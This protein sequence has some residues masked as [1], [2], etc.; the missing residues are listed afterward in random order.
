M[1]LHPRVVRIQSKRSIG[2]VALIGLVPLALF[3]WAQFWDGGPLHSVFAQ[4]TQPVIHAVEPAPPSCLILNSDISTERTLII[5]GVDLRSITNPRLQIRRRLDRRDPYFIFGPEVNWESNRR[6]TLD[7][8]SLA[9][10]LRQSPVFF[11]QVR[12][13]DEDARGLSN[14]SDYFLLA[15]DEDSCRAVVPSPTPT[16]APGTLPGAYPV[17]GVAGDLWA[18]VVLGKPD[19]A[20]IA[21]KSV[22]PFKVNNPGGVV[23]DRSVEPGRAYIWDSGNNRILGIDLAECYAGDGAC[24]ATIV[25][26]QPSGYDHS[27]CNGDSG[28]Q[29]FPFRAQ[30]SAET[31]CGVPDHSLSPWE[32]YSFVTMAVGSD[33]SLFVPDF[34]NHRIL[35]Y[36][37]P[38]EADSVADQVWGQADFSGMVC[39]RGRLDRPTA[40]S[41]CF[42]SNSVRRVL[43]HYGAGVEIDAEG[44]MWVADVGNNRVLRFPANAATGQIS[45]AAD[46]VLGQSFF[47]NA[48]P[49]SALNRMHAPSSVTF[50]REGKLYVADAANDRILV[51]EPPF[52]SGERAAMTF[53][54]QLHHPT[55]VEFDPFGRG[56]WVVDAGNYMVELWDTTGASVNVVLGKTSYM[57]DKRCGPTMSGVPGWARLCPIGG[58]IGIDSRGNVLAP[59]YHDV[60]DVFRFPTSNVGADHGGLGINPVGRLFF[61]PFE[62]NFRDRHGIHSA[63]GVAAWKDQ[64]IVSDMKRL[65]YWNG[66]DTLSNG[67]PA[68]G[69]LGDAYAFGE[70]QYCCGRIKVD[71]AG[72][73]WVLSFE[74]RQFI[75]V[76]QLPLTEYSVPL[77]TFRKDEV[78]FPVLGTNER[79]ELGPRGFGI[80]PVGKGNLLWLGDTDNHRVLRI[81][82]PLT[83]PV[84]DMILGQ[85]DAR[86]TECNQDRTGS[87]R[88]DT[89]CYPGGLSIDKMGNLFV[90]DHALEVEGNFRLLVFL[91]DILPEGNDEVIYGRTASSVFRR[92]A[93]GRNN[94]W[95][96]PWEPTGVIQKHTRDLTAATWEVAFD[97]ANRMVTGYNAYI[98]PR[99][100]GVY[101]D[102]L[103][104]PE[105]PDYFLNDYGSM[106][107]TTTFDDNDN[108]Y[109]GDINRGRV[110]V[111]LNPFDNEQQRP[112]EAQDSDEDVPSPEYPIRI[113]AVGPAPPFCLSR[114]SNNNY[115]T[116][117]E[118]TVDSVPD[119][120]ARLEFRKVTSLHREFID[121]RDS[122]VQI[123]DSV[124]SIKGTWLW[125]RFWPHIGRATL[126]VR[127]IDGSDGKPISNWSPAFLMAN[128]VAA[129]GFS[130]STPTPTPTPTPTN[131][132]I[133]SP[134]PT[135]TAIPSPTPTLTPTIVPTP[136]P[137]EIPAPSPTVPPVSPTPEREILETDERVSEPPPWPLTATIVVVVVATI[138][139]V[140]IVRRMRRI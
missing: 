75:D 32:A 95:A 128:N 74:G 116:T 100:A 81:R 139:L 113:D 10:S 71:E 35:K 110:L 27:A 92:S 72:R 40:E 64:L 59:V 28:V 109:V 5:T 120:T 117:L 103:D 122:S 77:H 67:R 38:F 118:L 21:P 4:G 134:T 90:S 111:Y 37:N 13:L 85:R 79:I 130:A 73:L 45:K 54:S 129:C 121:M 51:F 127:I 138:A 15:R 69:V 82:D 108:L 6:I 36:E 96:N 99:F 33:S 52:E 46:I 135:T 137:T 41:L 94:V 65:M 115:E 114:S 98:G 68:D 2:I 43:N 20:Q 66:L 3:I 7:L 107:Y 87:L 83:N 57:P 53:A 101:E 88:M 136:T 39:N 131:T 26:G 86:S 76:Y 44:N 78:S 62:D 102:P 97:S 42:Q 112:T 91:A 14:W 61:P 125:G 22:V 16:P 31:L 48:V 19:F 140:Y 49:G 133:P 84:V 50:D 56:I 58:S 23:V 63:R 89:L 132:P 25:I 34:F 93:V 119:R 70:W 55:S 104:G 126:T 8:E 1:T 123:R 11:L 18:D 24:P 29:R 60:A 47:T 106:L 12:L 80:A 9:D 124:I 17:R 30:A 105:L